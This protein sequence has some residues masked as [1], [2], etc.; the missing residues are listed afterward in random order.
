MEKVSEDME[1][2]PANIN[3]HTAKSIGE[4]LLQMAGI[5]INGKNPWDIQVYEDDLYLR[6][7]TEGPL[8]LGE[9]YMDKW[10]DCQRV[11]MFIDKVLRANL[12][13]KVKIP[14]GFYLKQI[15]SRFINFQTKKRARQVAYAHYD[16]GNDLFKAMLD[17]N[18]IY[19]CGYWKEAVT[20]EEAQIAKLDLICR[21]LQLKPGLTLLDIGCGWGGLARHAAEKYGVN[22]TGVTISEQQYHYAKEHCKNLPINIH[23]QDY[24]DINQ[25][26][27]R[28]VSVGM[29]EHVGHI[30][31]R[32]FMRTA[33]QALKDD[34]LFLL[35]TI[36]VDETSSL[37]NEWIVKYIF[38]NGMLPSI[39][40]I[41]KSAEK[42]FIVEDW[43][44]F[45]A[46]YDNTL[47]AWHE[48]FTAQWNELK[49]QYD[50]RFYRM[51]CYY[52]HSCAGSF[53]ARKNQL[54]QIVLSK[55]GVPGGYLSPR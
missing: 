45:G 25:Q 43:Q 6:V 40:Q 30:N 53:R 51:W 19:S 20:L 47:M 26:F 5:T 9:A 46:Y 17:K 14:F 28:I 23:L 11:D 54:W 13:T 42:L 39:T 36:G 7:L 33:H 29:F 44:N 18:M 12:D 16:L 55:Y 27:D 52:L 10:W 41:A 32:T 2:I 50:E 34:G 31:Y 22:V 37:A 15:L 24:R 3:Q 1:K 21:K 4:N 8:G 38:P 48:N 35:H 49:T